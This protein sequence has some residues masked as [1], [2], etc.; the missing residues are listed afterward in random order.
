MNR[1][2]I[3]LMGFKNQ[4]ASKLGGDHFLNLRNLSVCVIFTAIGS[5]ILFMLFL[6]FMFQGLSSN[7]I[8]ML[9]ATWL[10]FVGLLDR[11]ILAA[12]VDK[13]TSLMVARLV[14]IGGFIVIHSAVI[15]MQFFKGDIETNL[16]GKLQSQRDSI[17]EFY[18]PKLTLIDDEI[19][20]L[21]KENRLSIE[22]VNS[23]NRD[24]FIEVDNGNGSTR[25]SGRGKI[26]IVKEELRD[27][28]EA[29]VAS[30]M[31]LIDAQI[32]EAKAKKQA[33]LNDKEL[34]LGSLTEYRDSGVVSRLNA[35][36]EVVFHSGRDGGSSLPI[37]MF[38]F[39]FFIVAAALEALPLI[40]K[41]SYQN[42]VEAYQKRAQEESDLTQKYENNRSDEQTAREEVR[43]SIEYNKIT[44]TLDIDMKHGLFK[45]QMARQFDMM[46]TKERFINQILK[47]DE[48]GKKKYPQDIYEKYYRPEVIEKLLK[49]L[50]GEENSAA[51]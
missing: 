32:E 12:R 51:A 2:I 25:G 36:N 49:Q 47:M 43:H 11:T 39:A 28:L 21:T 30:E 34:A 4:I 5:A 14:V 8:L 15:E 10:C 13:D 27:R 16:T 23:A 22:K 37:V 48:E 19:T 44:G 45:E 50:S 33:V 24:I 42:S 1:T 6:K 46:K 20:A 38:Y 9:G 7:Q 26:A 18:Q 35:L 41:R 3:E 29:N 17:T 40:A 31:A